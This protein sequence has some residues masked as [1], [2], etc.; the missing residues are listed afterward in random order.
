MNLLK[1]FLLAV[2]TAAIAAAGPVLAS[3]HLDGHLTEADRQVDIN[4]M[5]VFPSPEQPERLVLVLNSHLGADKSTWFADALNYRFRLR[6]VSIAETGD[7]ARFNI[8]D[9]EISVNCMFSHI[10]GDKAGKSQ[11]GSCKSSG[12]EIKFDVGKATTQ[13]QFRKTGMRV[14]AGRR[15]DP[16]FMDV[17]GFIKSNETGEL[18]FTKENALENVNGMSIVV[19]IDTAKFLPDVKGMYGI[20]SEIRTRG[21]KSMVIDTFGRPEV[22]NVIL[23]DPG[24]DPVNQSI[25]VRDLFYQT[26][27]FGKPS[28]YAE[29]FT[30]RFNANLHKID[31][32]DGVID[33]QMPDG[34]HPLTALQ[35]A[36]FTVIDLS[37]PVSNGSWFEIERAMVEGRP[38]KTGGGRWLNDDAMDTQLTYLIARDN[39]IISDG[40]NKPTELASK[41]FPYLRA[42]R[43]S[44]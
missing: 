19:E 2:S 18:R 9:R 41:T 44:Q 24:Y 12:A 5:Y 16:F 26:D 1:K 25:D 33:W 7:K 36:D 13:E 39:R 29:A 30:A 10:H 22:T 31:K 43:A 11:T 38:H 28:R 23:S 34:Q 3:D 6:P 35:Q 14:W 15:L 32:L 27:P 17:K 40:V 37:K 42:P 8:G 20:V 4:D 21:S